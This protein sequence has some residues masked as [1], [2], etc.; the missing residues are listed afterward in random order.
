M[1][2]MMYESDVHVLHIYNIYI[3]EAE[4]VHTYL[5]PFILVVLFLLSF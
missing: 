4:I 2:A 5:H 3:L 1:S